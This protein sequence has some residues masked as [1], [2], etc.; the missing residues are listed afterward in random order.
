MYYV[1]EIIVVWQT[2]VARTLVTPR[3]CARGKAFSFVRPFV[4]LFVST[5]I[6]TSQVL[7]I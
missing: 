6:A 2:T 3:T 4:G 5:K 7:G 1:V